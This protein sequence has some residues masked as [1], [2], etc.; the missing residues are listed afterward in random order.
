VAE[1]AP[2]ALPTPATEQTPARRQRVLRVAGL[3]A[4]AIPFLFLLFASVAPLVDQAVGSLFNWSDI[5]PVSFA[6]LHYYG[7][8]LADPIATAAIVHTAIYVGITVPVEV[9]LGVGGAWLVYRARRGRAALTALFVLPLVIPWSSTAT[10]FSGVLNATSGLDGLVDR[11]IGDTI[12]LAWDLNPRLAFGVIVFVGIWKGAPWCFLLM[13]A[14][15]STAPVQLFEAGRVDGARGLSYWRYVVIPTVWPML[16]FVTIFR[17]FTEA[18]MV[19]SVNLLTQGGPFDAT[20]LI[21]SYAT[22]LAF[23]SFLFAESEALATATG[24]VLLVAALIALALLYRPKLPLVAPIGR[25]VRSAGRVV[26]RPGRQPET[27]VASPDPMVPHIRPRPRRPMRAATLVGWFGASKRRAR[28]LA[29][30]ALIVAGAIEL[31]PLTSGLRQGALGPV[32]GLAWP[33]VETG[34]VN[35]AIMTVGTVVGT[36]VLAVP[37]AYVL[38]QCRFR[39]RSALFALV[40]VAIAIPGALTLFP[41]ARG[42]VMMGLANTR[43]GVMLIYVSLDLPLAIF[44][45][46]AAF[47][48]VPRPLVEAMRV[49]GASTA[50][51]AARLYLP[52][53]AS[54][55]VVVTVLTVL[56]V[57][58]DAVIMLVMTNGPSLYTLPVLVAA[59]LGGTAALGASWLSIAPPLLIFL[60]SQR[61]FHRGI[62]PGPLL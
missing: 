43:L 57:W 14:A 17:L 60:A 19:A 9:V 52:M 58:N 39:G 15:F 33:E 12:P 30:V 36:L 42:L 44:F 53:S 48:A 18:Q 4:L 51:I 61:H 20:Q 32:F 47:A 49:D 25:A 46:R 5:H 62:A 59:G 34:L 26:H 54:T 16:V 40:L 35:S 38:A 41:Q 28:R 3:A 29:A 24:A 13:L 45:L 56:Q 31:V 1:R 22:N 6:G 10:L 50:R 21:G 23:G 2:R 55:L 27:G 7:D 8:L 37:A 11:V